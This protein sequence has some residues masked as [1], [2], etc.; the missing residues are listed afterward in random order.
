M[1]LGSHFTASPTN[2]AT[3]CGWVFAETDLLFYGQVF[4]ARSDFLPFFF[5]PFGLVA[6]DNLPAKTI[7]TA[8]YCTEVV[9]PKV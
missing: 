1:K 6:P 8:K 2:V 4:R 7:I 3:V 5:I 9:L